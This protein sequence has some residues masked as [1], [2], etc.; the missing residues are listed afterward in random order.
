ML[1]KTRTVIWGAALAAVVSLFAGAAMAEMK[2]GFVDTA[3]LMESAPQV[4]EAQSKIEAEFAPRE[5]ELVE[6]QRKIR[7]QEDRLARDSAVM[8]ESEN[9][10]LERDI[11]AMRRDLKRSQEE[12][13][14]DLNIRRNEVLAKLQREIFD[15]IVAFAKVQNYDLIMGQGVVYSSERVDITEAVLKELTG[16]R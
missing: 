10:K 15:A 6:L 3:K 7:T 5:K 2:V 9:T 12:F 8:S 4:K 11:L 16:G 1:N 13:R 14:D